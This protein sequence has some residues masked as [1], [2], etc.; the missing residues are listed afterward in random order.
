MCCFFF[1][2]SLVSIGSIRI[3]NVTFILVASEIW[4]KPQYQDKHPSYQV[5]PN[6]EEISKQVVLYDWATSSAYISP[7]LTTGLEPKN[8]WWRLLDRVTG[9]LQDLC[10]PVGNC[11]ENLIDMEVWET[12]GQWRSLRETVAGATHACS[13]SEERALVGT[14][15]TTRKG[16]A[17]VHV[18]PRP[19]VRLPGEV[20]CQQEGLM[21]ET[22]RR[23]VRRD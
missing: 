13:G 3:L 20:D 11:W 7:L 18:A 8:W 17:K 23:S 14:V 6:P 10:P 22:K 15:S 9:M 2:M 16:V 12:Q 5:L 4:S 1:S 21:E 19:Q